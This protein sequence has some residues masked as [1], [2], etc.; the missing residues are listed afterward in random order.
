MLRLWVVFLLG[1]VGL[2]QLATAEFK[3]G[4]SAVNITPAFEGRP[5]NDKRPLFKIGDPY[6]DENKDKKFDFLHLGGFGPYYP[7]KE[8]N[9]FAAGVHDP[10]WSRALAIQ[11]SNGTIVVLV[12]NDLPGLGWKHINPVRRRIAREF[13]I[14]TSNIII[15][16]THAHAGPDAVGYWTTL[17]ADHNWRYNKQL[18]EWMYE[19]VAQAIKNLEPALMKTVTT[20]HDACYDRLTFVTKRARDCKI[21]AFADDYKSK[22]GLNYDPLL[23]QADKRDPMVF[24]RRIVAAQFVSATNT[25][26]TLATF[27]DWNNHPD[28]LG[29]DNVYVSSDYPHYLR[30]YMESHLGGVSV[31]FTGTLGSQIGSSGGVPTPLWD[32]NRKPVYLDG[33]RSFIFDN[34]WGKI[35]SI[36]YEVAHEA[37][38]ALQAETLFNAKNDVFVKTEPVDVRIDNILH[39]VGTRSVW[40][41]FDVA[42]KDK[43][44]RDSPHCKNDLGCVRSDISVVSVGDLGLVA[45]PGEVDPAYLLGRGESKTDYG[46]YGKKT[47]DAMPAW[48]AVMPGK[49]HAVLGQANGYLSYLLHEPD[50]V[51]WWHFAHPLHYEEFVTVGKQFGDDAANKVMQL[52][53]SKERYSKKDIY[54]KSWDPNLYE[55]TDEQDPEVNPKMRKS[56]FI[57]RLWVRFLKHLEHRH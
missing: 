23:I 11:G 30:D 25:K 41:G 32:E 57:D 21:P 10:I 6:F 5:V 46:T 27:V 51:G 49:H 29:G 1:Q 39:K 4:A 26:L 34:D 55:P 8:P 48:D 53:G 33:K 19:S 17:L 28:T 40:R 52:L 43:M 2:A 18:R 12:S 7:V 47:F 31:Y 24:N 15:T 37:V 42:P 14:P 36:G 56:K 20:E 50:N 38:Q 35:R 54:P 13:K 45:L 22:V 44:V 16:S 3:V 9:R